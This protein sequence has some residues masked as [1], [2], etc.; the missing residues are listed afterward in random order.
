V[1]TIGPETCNQ[2]LWFA[3]SSQRSST[4]RFNPLIGA[5]ITLVVAYE[6]EILWIG[7]SD[8]HVGG[9]LDFLPVEGQ[10]VKAGGRV[11]VETITLQNGTGEVFRP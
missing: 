11:I 5:E 10:E 6:T 4:W 1:L 3:P 9:H 2:E 7:D 8:F